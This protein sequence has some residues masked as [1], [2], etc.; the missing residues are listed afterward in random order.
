MQ[1]RQVFRDVERVIGKEIVQYVFPKED[2]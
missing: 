2:S 1:D